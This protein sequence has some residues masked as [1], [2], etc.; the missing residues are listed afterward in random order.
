MK[1]IHFSVVFLVAGL[2]FAVPQVQKPT[3]KGFF[4]KNGTELRITGFKEWSIEKMPKGVFQLVMTGRP[5]AEWLKQG[6]DLKASTLEM[7][8]SAD[9]KLISADLKG[10]IEFSSQR[11]NQDRVDV[12]AESATYTEADEK[13]VVRGGLTLDQNSEKSGQTLHAEGSGGTVFLDRKGADADLIKSATLSGP[14]K[15][16]LTG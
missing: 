5:H 8:A 14:I 9:Y 3:Q 13:L 16:K 4:D 10:G 2:V 12:R 11:P 6:L 7:E 1:R 15:F